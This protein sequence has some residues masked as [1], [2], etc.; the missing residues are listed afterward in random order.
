MIITADYHTHTNYS[1]GKGTPE[2]NVLAA[3]EKGNLIITDSSN[4]SLGDQIAVLF[5]RIYR[6][7]DTHC[8]SD[9]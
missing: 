2:E 9:S 6:G 3:I 4:E 1:H 7:L 5:K 8:G